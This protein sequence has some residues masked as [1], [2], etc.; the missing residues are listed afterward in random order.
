MSKLLAALTTLMLLSVPAAGSAIRID[1]KKANQSTSPLK[2]SLRTS[3][4]HGLVT[5]SLELP[6][7]QVPLD[8]LWRIY[9]VVRKANKATLVSV[10]LQTTPDGDVLK[11][12]LLLDPSAM[13]D[14]EIWIRTGEHAPLA[15]TIYAID[16][17]SFQ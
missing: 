3:T 9:L 15:E 11:T 4:D 1:L 10:P 8:H 7:K 6:R 14:V 17:G 12:E 13:K 16:V 5:V 2:Y